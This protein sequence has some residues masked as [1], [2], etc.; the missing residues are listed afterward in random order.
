MGGRLPL[1]AIGE[2]FVGY[3]GTRPAVRS[4]SYREFGRSDQWVGLFPQHRTVLCGR[5]LIMSDIAI[6]VENLS[7][8][9]RIGRAKRR[10]DTLRDLMVDTLRAPF[11]SRDGN[12]EED[13]I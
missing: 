5:D 6:R 2:P 12:P 11:R 7:K 4:V 13:T 8:M 1:G 9:Y 10:H 3:S